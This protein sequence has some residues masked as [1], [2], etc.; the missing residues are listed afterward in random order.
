VLRRHIDITAPVAA[1][2]AALR[3]AE[4]QQ[5]RDTNRMRAAPHE[6]HIKI[7]QVRCGLIVACGWQGFC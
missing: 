4:R 1:K 5:I 2:Y 3:A 7:T 6:T